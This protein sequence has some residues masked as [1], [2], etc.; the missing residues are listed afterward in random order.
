MAN[1]IF[2]YDG[3]LHNSMKVYEPSFR[4]AYQWL[5]EN[6]YAEEKDFSFDEI[7][8]WLGFNAAD[9][10]KKFQPNL[11]TEITEKARKIL[12]NCMD[13]LVKSGKAELF[14]GAEK[15]LTELKNQGHTLIFLSN[16]R[17]RYMKTHSEAFGLERFFD[18]FYCCEEYD[19]I[20]KYQIFRIISLQHT[21]EYIVI[22]DRFHDMETAEKNG[23][24]SI[25][26]A[27]GYGNL[28][29][30]KTADIIVNSINE[31]PAAVRSLWEDIK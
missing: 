6:N 27:Y 25:G 2:D 15:I 17:V 3:T 29:E 21:G 23:L 28:E 31:I 11:D 10:W 26:C 22:G 8:Y 9:M 16:C 19:F 1:L 24:K 18:Y 7:S 14:D 4:K 30:L 20:P 12:G 13:G 5:V